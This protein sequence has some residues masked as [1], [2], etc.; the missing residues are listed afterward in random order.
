MR[1]HPT[2]IVL[3]SGGL[4]SATV[5]AMALAAGRRCFALSYQYGQRHAAELRA[6]S[7]VA[8]SLGAHRHEIWAM[9]W[10]P[11]R[12]SSLTDPSAPMP[13]WSSAQSPGDP[14]APSTYVPARNTV[15]LAMALSYA[16]AS[17]AAEIHWGAQAPGSER[18]PDCRPEFV[19]AFQALMEVATVAG[20]IRLVTPLLHWSKARIIRE[21]TALGV[22]YGLTS[23][24]YDPVPAGA[25]AAVGQPPGP[26]SAAMACGVCEACHLR[27]R[28]FEEAGVDD[29]TVY[30][31]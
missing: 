5:L 9:P 28:G 12:A 16:E 6:A 21:G 24:C 15:F 30:R 7:R 22:D 3:L 27:R 10:P 23:S 20:G 31:V 2:A 19:S 14:P 17:G 1:G 29:P 13:A 4:D 8:A 26:D 18:Y 11:S 25:T